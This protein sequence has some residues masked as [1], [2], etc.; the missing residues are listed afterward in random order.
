MVESL[1][2]E[3]LFTFS[4][5]LKLHFFTEDD[6]TQLSMKSDISKHCMYLKSILSELAKPQEPRKITIIIDDIS[7]FERSPFYDQ[8]MVVIT[9]LRQIAEAARGGYFGPLFSFKYI[10]VHPFICPMSMAEPRLEGFA[11]MPPHHTSLPAAFAPLPPFQTSPLD[12]APSSAG[13]ATPMVLDSSGPDIDSLCIE[14]QTP[15]AN[16]TFNPRLSLYEA[17]QA[18]VETAEHDR[19]LMSEKFGGPQGLDLHRLETVMENDNIISDF[20]HGD[21]QILAINNNESQSVKQQQ[22]SLSLLVNRLAEDLEEQGTIPL[23]FFAGFHG[24]GNTRPALVGVRGLLHVF[25]SQLLKAF[26]E[27]IK[28]DWLSDQLMEQVR[29]GDIS[30]LCSLMSRMLH[31][32]TSHGPPRRVFCIVDSIQHLENPNHFVEFKMLVEYL[33][34]LTHQAATSSNLTFYCVFIHAHQ[35]N[36]AI[37]PLFGE[38]ETH[39]L[40]ISD[41]D[42]KTTLRDTAK[43]Q[44]HATPG[45]GRGS[46]R[47]GGN[48]TH[49]DRG[50]TVTTAR[51]GLTGRG[52]RTDQDSVN[53]RNSGESEVTH[54]PR[55]MSRCRQGGDDREDQSRGRSPGAD[56]SERGPS[57]GQAEANVRLRS[58]DTSGTTESFG[59]GHGRGRGR[60]VGRGGGNVEARGRSGNAATES[61]GRGRGAGGGQGRGGRGR[62]NAARRA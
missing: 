1:M 9:F 10:L 36:T 12:L 24:E 13:T 46:G 60:G 30:A 6:L 26:Q 27:Y 56:N 34:R 43:Q 19:Q 37:Q 25:N 40:S 61:S 8:W 3:L 35:S 54:T 31:E 62:G 39:T 59:R 18:R 42:Y 51:L 50:D 55:R 57:D 44:A 58:G 7:P 41:F 4:G 21:S 5:I 45:R 48:K 11:V 14:G 20:C 29:R 52:G 23:N 15:A 16:E 33:R 47:L 38:E 28:L 53:I 2:S 49:R 17:L 32:A 22:S